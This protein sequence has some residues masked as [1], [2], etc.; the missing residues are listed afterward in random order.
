MTFSGTNYLCAAGETFDT[1]A[2]AVYGDEK[3]AADILC[4]NPAL[5]LKTVFSGGEL[6]DLPAVEIPEEGE[7][8]MP[9]AA[10]WKED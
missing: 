2:L 8:T 3:Y 6:R 1:V 7:E 9:A 10:P 4:A 5:C